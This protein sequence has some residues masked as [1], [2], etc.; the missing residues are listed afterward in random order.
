MAVPCRGR[1]RESGT[2][3]GKIA[4]HGDVFEGGFCGGKSTLG[5]FY[6]YSFLANSPDLA[7][8]VRQ[9]LKS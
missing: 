3:S 7:K 5:D 9:R 4:G 6:F 2:G 8:S 1:G